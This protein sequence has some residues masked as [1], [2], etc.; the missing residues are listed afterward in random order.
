VGLAIGAI[1]CLILTSC[2]N[3]IGKWNKPSDYSPYKGR[4]Y[5]SFSGTPETLTLYNGQYEASSGVVYE[6]KKG[7]IEGSFYELQVC[8]QSKKVDTW[9]CDTL[10]IP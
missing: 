8:K 10:K 1:L 5:G 3:N 4:N 7:V 2:S 6:T 9:S